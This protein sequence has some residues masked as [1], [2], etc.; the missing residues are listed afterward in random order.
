MHFASNDFF[1]S[2]KVSLFRRLYMTIECNASPD[3]SRV[4]QV[5]LQS[6]TSTV[7]SFQELLLFQ[8]DEFEGTCRKAGYVLL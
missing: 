5:R 3:I 8:Y 7:N 4:C 1:N 6:I 2:T